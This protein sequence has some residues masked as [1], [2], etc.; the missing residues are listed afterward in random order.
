MG[1][2]G[3]HGFSL[4]SVVVASLIMTIS[5]LFVSQL[6]LQ[7]QIIGQ[8]Q[9]RFAQF[10][11]LRDDMMAN[12]SDECAIANTVLAD[13]NS[14]G[15]K[16]L[17]EG[18][19]RAGESL[20][21]TLMDSRNEAVYGQSSTKNRLLNTMG[22]P[23]TEK[24]GDCTHAFT[25][26]YALK[27][28]DGSD[29]KLPFLLVTGRFSEYDPPHQENE[30]PKK[31]VRSKAVNYDLYRF[32]K[33]VVYKRPYLNCRDVMDRGL[34]ESPPVQMA[35]GIYRVDPDGAGGECPFDVYCDLAPTSDGGGWALVA[36]QGLT[37]ETLLEREPP[38]YQGMTG[39]LPDKLIKVLLEHSSS[40]ANNNVRLK[41]DS[42]IAR[43]HVLSFS[44]PKS[45]SAGT[46]TTAQTFCQAVEP[47]AIATARSSS[48]DFAFK[49]ASKVVNIGYYDHKFQCDNCDTGTVSPVCQEMPNGGC[50]SKTTPVEGSV[51]VR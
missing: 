3:Q 8:Q 48:G 22:A 24:S 10:N 34:A 19:C 31:P 25:M 4:V 11:D 42:R 44:I 6:L 37:S 43:K 38:L 13:D 29:C 41:I 20:P 50:C 15:M 12:L 33:Q 27:C 2:R 9:D 28:A 23:C 5:F 1:A 32:E 21:L 36:N 51:W 7:T 47:T 18:Q 39:R 46:Y 35:S 17:Y 30:L 45:A 14:E 26:E 49:A 40:P 16:C